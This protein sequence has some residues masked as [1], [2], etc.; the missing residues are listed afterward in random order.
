[1]IR[2]IPNLVMH[3]RGLGQNHLGS[4]YI[5]T[6]G[7]PKWYFLNN[8]KKM[9]K[10]EIVSTYILAAVTAVWYYLYTDQSTKLVLPKS[11]KNY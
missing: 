2:A 9:S 6:K 4:A 3:I 10:T 7:M 5:T 1:M 8:D 11:C